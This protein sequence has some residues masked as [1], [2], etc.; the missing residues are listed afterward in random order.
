MTSKY[1]SAAGTALLAGII[2]A[3]SCMAV[4]DDAADLTGTWVAYP[5]IRGHPGELIIYI[6]ASPEE[7]LTASIELPQ[8][9]SR[10]L[11]IGEVT[12]DGDVVRVGPLEFDRDGDVMSTVLPNTFI[13]NYTVTAEFQKLSEPLAERP[14][15]E[16]GEAVWPAWRFE[17]EGA[18]WGGAL[19]SGGAVYFGN[20]G[21]KLFAVDASDGTSLWTIETDGAVRS[22][23]VSVDT[24]ILFQSDDGYLYRV[25]SDDGATVWRVSLARGEHQA[26]DRSTE[27]PFYDHY[28]S[29]V[30]LAEGLGYVGTYEGDVVCIDLATGDVVWRVET[31]GPVQGQPVISGDRVVAASFDQHVYALSADSGETVWKTEVGGTVPSYPAIHG[32]SIVFV[33]TRGFDLIALD[34]ESG[35]RIWDYY[36][37]FSWV[38]SPPLV[39]GDTVLAGGSDGGAVLAFGAESGEKL[40]EFD[41]TG[42]VWAPLARSG[43]TIYAGAVGVREYTVAHEP[44]FFAIDLRTGEALWNYLPDP[45]AIDGG[46][47][48]GFA[49]APAVSSTHVFAGS[50]DGKLYAFPIHDLISAAS[51]Y[52][53][54]PEDDPLY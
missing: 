5:E 53:E 10:R 22:T 12:V 51:E 1:R 2:T 38:D 3:W 7:T 23:P 34:L 36:F 26:T 8:I 49:A 13:A 30:T 9:E 39:A 46:T 44:G 31:G 35:Q 15:R 29:A 4:A 17:T 41:T 45:I 11:S 47:Q 52:E 40:W 50:L 48:S 21:G 19:V 43:N 28:A 25:A 54:S 14:P 18:I 42:S 37:W 24:D 20:D 6:E 27:D 33:G 16:L 32:D